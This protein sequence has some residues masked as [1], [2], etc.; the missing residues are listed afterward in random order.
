MIPAA[1]TLSLVLRVLITGTGA[2]LA[3]CN[4]DSIWARV[5]GIG[6]LAS[7]ALFMFALGIGGEIVPLLLGLACAAGTAHAWWHTRY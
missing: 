1:S 5:L 2:Y 6:Y 4:I 3:A 7:T